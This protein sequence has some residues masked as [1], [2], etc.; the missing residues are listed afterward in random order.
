MYQLGKYFASRDTVVEIVRVA[1]SELLEKF[2]EYKVFEGQIGSFVA[3]AVQLR[4][5]V[6]IVRREG[7]L[8][9]TVTQ[10]S[11][12]D[13]L[14]RIARKEIEACKLRFAD[15]LPI[16]VSTELEDHPQKPADYVDSHR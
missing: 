4:N 13:E 5:E 15:Q 7:F 11:Y 9:D 8:Q 12:F 3:R 16:P 6:G 1:K 10:S 2:P 14:Y